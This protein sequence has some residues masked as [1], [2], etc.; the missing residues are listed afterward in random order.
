M[1]KWIETTPDAFAHLIELHVQN[2]CQRA[3][4]EAL[5]EAARLHENINPASDIERGNKIPGAGA[6]GA[7]IEYRDAIRALQ[8]Y[9][10]QPG[11]YMSE[12][13][14]NEIFG[15]TSENG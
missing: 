9:P 2:E 14:A 8:L 10:R 13:E 3:R 15:N 7:I 12:S 11:A 5:E 1:S 4:N 6:M